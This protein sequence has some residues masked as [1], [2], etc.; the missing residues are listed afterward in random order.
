[1]TR[2]LN[3]EEPLH[4][5]TIAPLFLWEKKQRPQLG[6]EGAGSQRAAVPRS[7]HMRG[8]RRPLSDHEP[9]ALQAAYNLHCKYQ[10]LQGVPRISACAAVDREVLGDLCAGAGLEV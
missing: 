8:F 1:M 9:Y 6:A 4:G 10:H 7:Q 2:S 3:F 5:E